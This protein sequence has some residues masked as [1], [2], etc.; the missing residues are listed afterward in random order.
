MLSEK[1]IETEF[2]KISTIGMFILIGHSMNSVS[3]SR[4]YEL[5]FS[6][7]N[8][9]MGT[10]GI[11]SD[12]SFA[13]YKFPDIAGVSGA[14]CPCISIINGVFR[15]FYV[16]V[17]K[18]KLREFREKLTVLKNQT[19]NY[20]YSEIYE[21]ITK[22]NKFFMSFLGSFVTAT[23]TF[24]CIL[25]GI[26]TAYL[27]LRYGTISRKL[28]VETTFYIDTSP[29]YEIAYLC[30]SLSTVPAV[31]AINAVDGLFVGFSLHL[32][33]RFDVIALEIRTMMDQEFGREA[34]KIVCYNREQN[35]RILKRMVECVKDHNLTI[36]LCDDFVRLFQVSV[37]FLFFQITLVIGLTCIDILTV[38]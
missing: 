3:Q 30:Q 10:Y 12:I 22:T 36:E 21:N 1:L 23:A 31:A 5:F 15:L 24:Y 26:S 35:N 16:L 6:L 27:Y 7:T 25:P 37:I 28:P 13:I 18:W 17:N 2:Y 9:V 4:L 32:K 34:K 20:R 38:S 14:I 19:Y 11:A 29:Y 8:I 33:A